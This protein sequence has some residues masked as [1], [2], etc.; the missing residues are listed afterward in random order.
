MLFLVGMSEQVQE[1]LV[2]IDRILD[3][4]LSQKIE[5]KRQISRIQP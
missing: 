1:R 4:E 3:E 5:S 2:P